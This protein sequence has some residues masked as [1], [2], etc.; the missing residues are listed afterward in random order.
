MRNKLPI[1]PIIEDGK[2][3]FYNQ[4]GAKVYKD[5]NTQDLVVYDK[6]YDFRYFM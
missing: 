4:R 6:P 5:I 1:E 2:D 3:Y